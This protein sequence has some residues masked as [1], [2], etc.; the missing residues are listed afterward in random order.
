MLYCLIFAIN[1]LHKNTDM[2]KLDEDG[3][4]LKGSDSK[5]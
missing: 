5:Q 1:I 3:G 2:L 4:R